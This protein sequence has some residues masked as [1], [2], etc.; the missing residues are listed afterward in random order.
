MRANGLVILQLREPEPFLASGEGAHNHSVDTSLGMLGLN[1]LR[2]RSFPLAPSSERRDGTAG[3]SQ[4]SGLGHG[5]HVAALH[6]LGG[7]HVHER[8]ILNLI[9]HHRRTTIGAFG[10]N[11]GISCCL[12]LAQ[13]TI[14]IEVS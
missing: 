12:H 13:A 6:L 10:S 8:A 3:L 7:D 1:I 5:R 4:T 14:A 2:E 11:V 9:G